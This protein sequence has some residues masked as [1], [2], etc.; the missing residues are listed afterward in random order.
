MVIVLSLFLVSQDPQRD[1][2]LNL[3]NGLF[4]PNDSDHSIRFFELV[5]AVRNVAG[6]VERRP[7]RTGQGERWNLEGRTDP[8]FLFQL[9][10]LD[11]P[12]RVELPGPTFVRSKARFLQP[13]EDFGDPARP[14]NVTLP[15]PVVK[16]NE[17]PLK[18]LLMSVE[19]HLSYLAHCL[20]SCRVAL[21][22]LLSDFLDGSVR[23]QVPSDSLG[24]LFEFAGILGLKVCSDSDPLI[25]ILSRSDDI[26]VLRTRLSKKLKSPLRR[27]HL[28][29]CGSNGVDLADKMV[30]LLPR[31]RLA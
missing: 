14:E 26:K 30:R 9:E 22:V 13:V 15:V 25:Q 2:Q 7:V 5:Q 21:L 12:C 29:Q 8:Q 28:D 23:V 11:R 10:S 4:N 17:C 24:Q 1:A 16:V 19:H 18:S 31:L 20:S 3:C 27:C 6:C